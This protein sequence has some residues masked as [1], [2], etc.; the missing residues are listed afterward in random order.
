M[1]TFN[2]TGKKAQ[3]LDLHL[4]KYELVLV[5]KQFTDRQTIL[6]KK[7]HL[8]R[9]ENASIYSFFTLIAFQ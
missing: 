8:C 2:R 7:I 1:K 6:E 3:Y 9:P 4:Y 5:C